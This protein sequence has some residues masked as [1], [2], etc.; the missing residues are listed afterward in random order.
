[1]DGKIYRSYNSVLGLIATVLF[2]CL[3]IARNSAAQEGAASAGSGNS[4]NQARFLFER[5]VGYYRS[6]RYEKALES[7]QE[8][9][10]VRPSPAVRVNI[11]NCYDQ[12]DRPLEA[13]FHYERFLA[14]SD[15][16]GD[17]RREVESAVKRLRS[18]IGDVA[19]Q[20][21]PEGASVQIDGSQR[22]QAPLIEPVPMVAGKHVIEVTYPDYQ[23]ERR[24][25]EVQGGKP[26]EVSVILRPQV[27]A[28]QTF[29]TPMVKPGPHARSVAPET[30]KPPVAGR[31]SRVAVAEEFN[32]EDSEYASPGSAPQPPP[33][34]EEVV[35]IP[36]P[37]A[38]YRHS[39]RGTAV[40]VSGAVTAGL[41]IATAVVG[42]IALNANSTYKDLAAEWKDNTLTPE[43][44]DQSRREANTKSASAQNL[45]L[46]TDILLAGAVVGATVTLCLALL[47]PK[48]R[49]SY[50]ASAV[51]PFVSSHG[52]GAL[53]TSSF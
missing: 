50:T 35:R 43:K 23:S 26:M 44:R 7:F 5:G 9:Y 16:G 25:I 4:R 40:F 34:S 10:N 46:G 48:P 27:A 18:K 47:W 1:M 36:N 2:I 28:A 24:E 22:R 32:P 33:V 3:A 13:I 49:E 14:E 51:L 39:S 52:A 20:V 15:I 53:L 8:A 11:A 38:R 12:M 42:G 45:A 21:V 30:E 17:Q 29:E 31:E 6:G 19:I 37:P 41:A